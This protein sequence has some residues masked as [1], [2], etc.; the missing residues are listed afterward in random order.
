MIPLVAGGRSGYVGGK[1][2]SKS[3]RKIISRALKRNII[4]QNL[5]GRGELLLC[6]KV[7]VTVVVSALS[8]L[9]FGLWWLIKSIVIFSD[10]SVV[11]CWLQPALQHILGWWTQSVSPRA[12]KKKT[13][14]QSQAP[15][16]TTTTTTTTIARAT[17][18]ATPTNQPANRP[19]NQPTKLTSKQTT[20]NK[21]KHHNP[22]HPN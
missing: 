18:T 14:S 5:P 3:G 12:A 20:N 1:S 8:M 4:F 7:L 22:K 13:H 17:P 9:V 19:I 16:K 11:W 2:P 10:I 15:T 6:R 21:D